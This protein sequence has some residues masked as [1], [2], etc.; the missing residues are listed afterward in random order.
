[1]VCRVYTAGRGVTSSMPSAC[2]LGALARCS[3]RSPGPLFVGVCALPELRGGGLSLEIF[4][5]VSWPELVEYLLCA[6]VGCGLVRMGSYAF[7]VGK[8]PHMLKAVSV[9]P[10]GLSSSRRA[11]FREWMC[12]L[13]SVCC[14]CRQSVTRSPAS[15]GEGLAEGEQAPFLTRWGMVLK[16]LSPSPAGCPCDGRGLQSRS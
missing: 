6:A 3:R 12:F 2:L 7:L 11:G 16:L 4:A 15:S 8:Q 1:M 5:V 14:L 9:F 13:R 10:Q